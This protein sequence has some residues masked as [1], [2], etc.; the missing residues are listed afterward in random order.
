MLVC[1]FFLKYLNLVDV[2]DSVEL[3]GYY[4]VMW[5]NVWYVLDKMFDSVDYFNEVEFFLNWF[6]V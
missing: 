3:C 6:M 4:Y 5:S 1:L 2:I